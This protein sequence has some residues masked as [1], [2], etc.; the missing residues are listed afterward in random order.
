MEG[1]SMRWVYDPGHAWL[2]VTGDTEMALRCS[3]GYDYQKGDVVYLEEDCS[4][5]VYMKARGLTNDYLVGLPEFNFSPRGFDR[6]PAGDL[7]SL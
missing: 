2:E 7:G 5:G 4:V 3:T 1:V 6:P